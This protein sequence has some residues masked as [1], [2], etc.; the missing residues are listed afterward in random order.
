MNGT[1]P[2]HDATRGEA[3]CARCNLV[4]VP[5][6]RPPQLRPARFQNLIYPSE[7]SENRRTERHASACGLS[8]SLVACEGLRRR[9]GIGQIVRCGFDGILYFLNYCNLSSR[10]GDISERDLRPNLAN[11]SLFTFKPS[12]RA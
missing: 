12:S 6:G 3:T 5:D 1:L 4:T 11:A 9:G 2:S 8:E 7:L 10:L